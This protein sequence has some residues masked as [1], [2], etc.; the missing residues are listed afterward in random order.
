M[1]T[2]TETE[3]DAG[4]IDVHCH[5]YVETYL[6]YVRRNGAR[7]DA[8]LEP[9]E[10]GV[11]RLVVPGMPAYAMT[12]DYRSP[13][14]MVRWMDEAGLSRVVLTPAPPST[15]SWADPAITTELTPI[16]NEG[17]A[18]AV[19]RYPGRI[20][21]GAAVSLNAPERMPHELT[22]AVERL[23][24]RAAL[25]LTSVNG[26]NLDEPAFVPFFERAAEL[27]VPVF[28]HPNPFSP[29][30]YERL[31]RYYL[32]N[33]VGMTTDTT[34]AITSLIYSGLFERLPAL[35]VWFAHAG[36]SFAALRA[37]V[38]HAYHVRPEC[39]GLLPHPPSHYLRHL[40]FDSLA[41]DPAVLRFAVESFGVERVMVGSD[42]PYAIGTR[43]PLDIVDELDLSRADREAIRHR[44]ARAFFGIGA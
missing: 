9:G 30:G 18:A 36:G 39:Q 8:R 19:R 2:E 31:T 34:V 40:A 22:D 41:H 14:A 25:V 32:H 26:K 11:E 27:D 43:R 12:P 20:V 23:G 44:N 10:G 38:E 5:L 24:L 6:D 3:T 42:Y 7:L 35:R 37:R 16:V 33:V 4:G 1:E 13:E 15:W 17:I 28:V 29:V 21:G